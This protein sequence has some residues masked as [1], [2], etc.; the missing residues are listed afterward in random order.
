MRALVI[1]DEPGIARINQRALEA[2]GFE[3]ILGT[4]LAEGERLAISDNFEILVTDLKLPDG[5]GLTVVESFRARGNMTRILVVTGV[6][7]V[8]STVAALEAG[9]D[10]YLKK[11]YNVRELRARV[12]AL[13]R[14]GA[15]TGSPRIRC[16]NL[17]INQMTREVEVDGR[18]VDLAP[19]E[20]ALLEYFTISPRGVTISRTELLE[21]L[22]RID[23]DTR[24]NIVDVNVAR[25][26]GKLLT[27][28][29]TCR[30]ESERGVGYMFSEA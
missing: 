1:E 23:F 7:A 9:A 15:T 29:A 14:R 24:T 28:G 26:R 25:L 3:V 19:K 21:K 2:E 20:F 30:I 11:P 22:W 10:D 6:D 12:R 8:E 4:T 5:H 13:M 18:R 16:A 27:A 17:S